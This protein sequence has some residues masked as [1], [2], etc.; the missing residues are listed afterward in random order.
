MC[1]LLCHSATRCRFDNPMLLY[2]PVYPTR[3]WQELLFDLSLLSH[4]S[5]LRYSICMSGTL[6]SFIPLRIWSLNVKGLQ[7]SYRVR[8]NQWLRKLF[9]TSI[10][11][12][13]H[14]ARI[15]RSDRWFTT[16]LFRCLFLC[17]SFSIAFRILDGPD[18]SGRLAIMRN[19]RRDQNCLCFLAILGLLT[20]MIRELDAS[21]MFDWFLVWFNI[22]LDN[23]KAERVTT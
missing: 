8:E 6:Y 11:K 1:C 18:I 9:D 2:F 15:L 10:R 12:D 23:L 4:S 13:I 5:H 22:D 3:T 19:C 21:A 14:M 20:H 16:L 17:H 7:F